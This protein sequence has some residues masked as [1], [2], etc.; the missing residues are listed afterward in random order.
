M[1]GAPSGR[2]GIALLGALTALV[3]LYLALFTPGTLALSPFTIQD[4]ARQFQSWMPRLTDPRLL[5]GD[6]IANYWHAMSPPVYRW[7]FEAGAG[8]GLDPIMLGRLL[9]VPL[10]LLS[11]W[12]AWR[13]ALKLTPDP[14][15]AFFAAAFCLAYLVHDDSLFSAT[16]RAFSAPLLL[17]ALNAVVARRAWQAVAWLTLLAAIYPTSAIAGFGILGL[18]RVRRGSRLP[19]ELEWR[20]LPPLIVGAA[21]IVLAALPLQH[22]SQAWGPVITLDQAMTMP[23]M[24]RPDGR[25]SIVNA[26]GRIAWVCSPRVGYLPE[27]LPCSWN[28]PGAPAIDALLMVPLLLLAIRAARGRP[29]PQTAARGRL[30]LHALVACSLCF[31]V[32]AVFAF[33]LHFP[34][35]YTQ[36]ILGPLEWL[37]TGQ[38]LGAWLASRGRAWTGAAIALVAVSAATPLAGLVRPPDPGLLRFVRALP[39]GARIG[40]VSEELAVIPALAGHSITAAPEQAIPWHMGYYGPFERNLQRALALVSA[41][42]QAGMAANLDA[43]YVVVD[44]DLL[45]RSVIPERYHQIVPDD[46]DAAQRSFALG[47]SA[48]QRAAPRC[49][50]YRGPAAWV[51]DGACLRA[52]G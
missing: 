32:A 7:L 5:R 52:P 42:T 30:F 2:R 46:A 1:S 19:L 47:P 31:G 3:Y 41:P 39:P 27:A 49:A 45:A 50:I 22:T 15:V 18:S 37:A 24:N 23:A 35:R 25:S 4:D 29:D 13:L 34:G 16:P 10:V 38:M 11:L 36:R 51:L 17:L 28:I 40:G 48:L 21:A 9:P 6:P 43:A 8:L 33:N 26:S 12:G 44:R 14:R 20:A